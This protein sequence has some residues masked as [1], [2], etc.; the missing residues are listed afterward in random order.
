VGERCTWQQPRSIGRPRY[1]GPDGLN[2]V[3]TAD[4]DE[5][6][7]APL[8]RDG[9][10]ATALARRRLSGSAVVPRRAEIWSGLVLAGLSV[11]N[12]ILLMATRTLM[13]VEHDQA[14]LQVLSAT[15]VPYGFE[16]TNI[17]TTTRRWIGR[18]RPSCAHHR[19][20]RAQKMAMPSATKLKRSADLQGIPLILT[21]ADEAPA[22]FEQHKTFKP[23]ADEYIFQ[24]VRCEE[25]R[26]KVDIS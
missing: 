13:C 22:K 26:R 10:L 20:G 6:A 23:H 3:F 19:L 1:H 15:L 14:A 12:V 24:A 5:D 7:L 18:A 16:I 21:S 9:V 8:G 11:V 2:Y 4:L 25:L 17:S